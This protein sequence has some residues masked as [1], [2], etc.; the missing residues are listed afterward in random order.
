MAKKIS[1]LDSY[2]SAVVIEREL[3]LKKNTKN[4]S[5]VGLKN[6]STITAVDT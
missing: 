3:L 2:V 6:V 1:H 5:T 4:I